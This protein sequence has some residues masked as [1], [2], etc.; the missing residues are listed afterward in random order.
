MHDFNRKLIDSYLSL[1][2]H[3]D[4]NSKLELISKLSAS[5][6]ESSTK[7]EEKKSFRHL[8]GAFNTEKTAEELIKEIK[9]SRKF[10][11]KIEDFD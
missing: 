10:T 11:R 6:K 9:E 7:K 4:T 8:F 5:M 1:I 3:L 2:N